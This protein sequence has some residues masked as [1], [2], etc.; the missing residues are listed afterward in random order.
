MNE[1]NYWDCN[2]EGDAMEG[3]VVCVDREGVP[4]ALNEKP[5][6]LQKYH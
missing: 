1:E 6:D 4:Q 3:P 2:V 5:L